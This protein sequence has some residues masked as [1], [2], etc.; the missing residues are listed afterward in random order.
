V[1][2]RIGWLET[3]GLGTRYNASVPLPKV[4]KPSRSCA[5]SGGE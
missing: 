2:S 3:V 4:A 1:T 5:N